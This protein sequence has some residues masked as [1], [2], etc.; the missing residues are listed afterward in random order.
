MKGTAILVLGIL[1]I[2]VSTYAQAPSTGQWSIVASSETNS[3]TVDGGPL[4]FV[5]DWTTTT[6]KG[7]TTI[8]TVLGYTYTNAGCSASGQPAAL[9][10]T[11][12][13]GSK[14][15][16]VLTVDNGQKYTFTTTSTGSTEFSGTF[17]S[18]GGG[19]TQ[20][21][22]GTFVATHYAALN[23]SFS[24]TIE[25]YLQTNTVNVTMTLATDANF[26]V[27]GSLKASNKACMANLTINGSA[28]QHY[29]P[30]FASGD[31][32][33]VFA[34]DNSGNVAAF[35]LSATD[36][37]GNLLSPAWPSQVYVTY[38]VLAGACSGDNGTDAPFQH[39]QSAPVPHAPI[40]LPV[41]PRRFR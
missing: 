10:A 9:T 22:S 37:N 21:D 29:G 14:T 16:I 3:N 24:G 41:L 33:V 28:A 8:A 18:S 20:A 36:Q 40:R 19:C 6:S 31:T 35:V 38:D 7:T 2:S 25:S 27:T 15:T 12:G 5:T 32:M 4:Q 39:V 34:S 1:L 30:S 26:N 17:T 13:S 11:V 23:G